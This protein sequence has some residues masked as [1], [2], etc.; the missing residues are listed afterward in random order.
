[1]TNGSTDDYQSDA[2]PGTVTL[3]V[4]D[5]TTCRVVR[6]RAIGGES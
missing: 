5:W 2:Y 6:D 1:M 4:T 3:I